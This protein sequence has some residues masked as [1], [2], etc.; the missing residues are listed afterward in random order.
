MDKKN[1]QKLKALNMKKG[2][3]DLKNSEL[4]SVAAQGVAKG[5]ALSATIGLVS[6]VAASVLDIN[7]Q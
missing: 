1:K 4:I 3:N 7:I 2:V 5:M 6:G